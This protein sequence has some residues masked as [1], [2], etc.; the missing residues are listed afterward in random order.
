MKESE[1][2]LGHLLPEPS[3]PRVKFRVAATTTLLLFAS[4]VAFQAL[5]PTQEASDVGLGWRNYQDVS[6]GRGKDD[7]GRLETEFGAESSSAEEGDKADDWG[8]SDTAADVDDPS[9]PIPPPAAFPKAQAQKVE[10]LLLSGALSSY[11]WH[12]TLDNL[13]TKANL[14]KRWWGSKE[15]EEIARPESRLIVVGQSALLLCPSSPR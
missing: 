8:S 10:R 6:W 11:S 5:G 2:L 15:L 7:F 1:S 14:E 12:A 3:H 4:Y 9:S 13:T